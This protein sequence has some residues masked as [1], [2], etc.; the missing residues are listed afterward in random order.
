VSES[1]RPNSESFLPDKAFRL[2]PKELTLQMLALLVLSSGVF[3]QTKSPELT[4]TPVS[5]TR[6]S[7]ASKA[8]D[9][10]ALL[11]VIAKIAPNAEGN[12]Q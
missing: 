4:L 1:R 2:D 3:V 5:P 12:R 7:E 10:A 6:L 11:D 8:H 9:V